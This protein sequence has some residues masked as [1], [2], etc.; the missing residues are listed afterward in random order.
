MSHHDGNIYGKLP[1]D[2]EFIKKI[3][4]VKRIL[5]KLVDIWIVCIVSDNQLLCPL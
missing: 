5:V 3:P 1:S 4:C 2:W